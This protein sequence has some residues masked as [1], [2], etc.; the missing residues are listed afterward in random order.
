[1][2]QLNNY[3]VKKKFDLEERT[4][5]FAENI[6]DLVKKIRINPV[7]KRIVEQLVGSGGSIGANYC[8]ATESESKKDFIHKV[9]IAKKEIKETKHWLRLLARSNDELKEELR[10]LWKES[11]E[12]LLI[13]SKIISSCRSLKIKTFENSLKIENSKIEN[14]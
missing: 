6:I 11:Q 14:S 7:N 1:M 9:G 2:N 12:L 8:E 10:S 4:A 13:F 5:K 3:Q